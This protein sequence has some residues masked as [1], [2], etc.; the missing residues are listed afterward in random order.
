MSI[1]VFIASAE[2]SIDNTVDNIYFQPQVND[3]DSQYWKTEKFLNMG[4]Y[5]FTYSCPNGWRDGM[6]G[7]L[8]WEV[9][10]PADY[11]DTREPNCYGIED[12]YIITQIKFIT[13]Y[14][15]DLKKYGFSTRS[16]DFEQSNP[17]VAY[18]AANND[19]SLTIEH[20]NVRISG[21][22]KHQYSVRLIIE[23]TKL[24]YNK[25]YYFRIRIG[26]TFHAPNPSLEFSA[27]E[28]STTFYSRSEYENSADY[29]KDQATQEGNESVGAVGDAVP[30]KASGFLNSF[31]KLADSMTTL[32]TKAQL[33]I[34]AISIPKTSAF[35][36]IKLT[37]EMTV[38]LG[39]W[40]QQIP[41]SVL[42]VVQIILTI[43]LILYCGYEFY[44]LI[45]QI[46]V[47]SKDGGNSG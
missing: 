2:T 9:T 30:D 47:K 42:T 38:D 34:P 22:D 25:Y 4:T 37:D 43:A 44:G 28:F 41:T 27:V 45:Q 15:M 31:Q 18:N 1:F 46:M 16:W 5:N 8:V 6:T 33:T 32:D 35:D 14:E 12:G 10:P 20:E 11:Q 21:K 24:K 7:V 40:V 29:E 23:S 3:T 17:I 39:Y 13:D 26:A 36:E 19:Y